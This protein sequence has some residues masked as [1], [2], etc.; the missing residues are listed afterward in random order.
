MKTEAIKQQILNNYKQLSQ[1][2][3]VKPEK[4]NIISTWG[5]VYR[6]KGA[7]GFVNQLGVI[8]RGSSAIRITGE[9]EILLQKKPFYITW[10]R[11]LKN[12]NTMLQN[13]IANIDNKNVVSK[14][15]V[16]ILCFP[17]EALERLSKSTK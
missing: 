9:N 11:A 2:A 16:N 14:R 15:V 8:E 17:K 10:K 12:V 4:Q 5:I 6:E 7:S 13:T 3:H 1:L